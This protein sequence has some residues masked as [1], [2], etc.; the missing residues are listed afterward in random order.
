M[1][2]EIAQTAKYMD[3]Y[4]RWTHR[5]EF[6]TEQ[7]LSRI[8]ED[9]EISDF[10]KILI[11]PIR[12]M[13]IGPVYGKA[14][15]D[16]VELDCRVSN[17]WGIADTLAHEFT[18]VEQKQT[19]RLIYQSG[20]NFWKTSQNVSSF[21]T[22]DVKTFNDY[23]NLPWEIEARKRGAKF[24]TDHIFHINEIENAINSGCILPYKA[25]IQRKK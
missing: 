20:I 2:I 6:V 12:S 13:R 7:L 8:K 4:N 22:S 3:Q 9:F 18:H 15:R 25:R 16:K 17:V 11:R 14:Y 24:C 1:K 5:V 23:Q 21:K 19:G 10:T